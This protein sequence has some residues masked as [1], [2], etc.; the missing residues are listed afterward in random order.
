L[1]SFCEVGFANFRPNVFATGKRIINE[2]YGRGGAACM[3]PSNIKKICS[4][5]QK[6][7]MCKK[8]IYRLCNFKRLE[9]DIKSRCNP[10]LQNA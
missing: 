6:T 8:Y 3:M 9:Q 5:Y 2:D 10:H 1:K 7:E 4:F